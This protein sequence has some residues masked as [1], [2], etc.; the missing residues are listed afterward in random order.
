MKYGNVC[1]AAHNYDNNKFFSK[2]NTLYNDDLIYIYNLNGEKQEYNVIENFETEFND[3]S[4]TS[5][6]TNDKHELTLVTCNNVTNKRIIVK[7][8]RK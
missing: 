7:A 4:C 6:E 1:I 3:T 2:I 5:Q 8:V